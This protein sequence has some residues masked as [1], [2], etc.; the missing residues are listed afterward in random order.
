MGWNFTNLKLKE[1]DQWGVYGIIF[2]KEIDVVLTFQLVRTAI[3]RKLSD[4]FFPHT[5]LEI[6]FIYDNTAKNMLFD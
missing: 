6:N 3:I 4:L 5:S 1:S 2:Y